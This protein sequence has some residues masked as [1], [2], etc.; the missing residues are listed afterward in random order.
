MVA[1]SS[2]HLVHQMNRKHTFDDQR[3][4]LGHHLHQLEPARRD[5]TLCEDTQA[6]HR[7]VNRRFDHYIVQIK[8]QCLYAILHCFSFFLHFGVQRFSV[9]DDRD[10]VAS[11]K[12]MVKKG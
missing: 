10:A 2:L 4:I 7:P 3:A 5:R 8:D 11:A 12:K 6:D 9:R 1:F